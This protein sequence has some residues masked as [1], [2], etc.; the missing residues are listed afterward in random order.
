MGILGVDMVERW[1]WLLLSLVYA[2][3]EGFGV[4]DSTDQVASGFGFVS[5]DWTLDS[6]G[7]N[8]IMLLSLTRLQ[9]CR[10][11]DLFMFVLFELCVMGGRHTSTPSFSSSERDHVCNVTERDMTGEGCVATISWTYL[12]RMLRWHAS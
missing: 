6:D 9:D 2:S 3:R 10:R 12:K 1:R 7:T 8:E 5:V 11:L 4:C